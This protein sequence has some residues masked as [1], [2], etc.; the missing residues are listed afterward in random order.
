MFYTVVETLPNEIES[1]KEQGEQIAELGM[2]NIA[3]L[4]CTSVKDKLAFED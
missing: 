3:S 2:L 1:F 4:I